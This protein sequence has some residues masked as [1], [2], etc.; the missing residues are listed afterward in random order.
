V[1]LIFS[2]E[3]AED[4]RVQDLLQRVLV[5]VRSNGYTLPRVRRFGDT[6]SAPLSHVQLLR[7]VNKGKSKKAAVGQV[8]L[9]TDVLPMAYTIG[10]LAH[11]KVKFAGEA[12]IEYSGIGENR[13]IIRISQC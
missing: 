10:M 4:S 5:D 13:L 9:A 8:A 7:L 2:Y 6:S 1:G 12:C 3:L 11:D